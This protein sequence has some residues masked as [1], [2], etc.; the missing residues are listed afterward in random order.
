MFIGMSVLRLSKDILDGHSRTPPDN[1]IMNRK[2]I[3]SGTPW[4]A[5]V[6]YSRAVRVGRYVHVSGSTATDA[7]GRLVGKGDARAQAEQTIANIERALIAAGSSLQDVVRT[8]IYVIDIQQDWE[9]VGETHARFFGDVCP[10]TSMVE[11]RRLIDPDML[12]EIEADAYVD[13]E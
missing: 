7:D 4:E 3:S 10:A 11:V 9:A 2:N 6:G 5:K 1:R 8:R 12:V 13:P